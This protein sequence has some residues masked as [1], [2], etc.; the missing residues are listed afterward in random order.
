MGDDKPPGTKPGEVKPLK[1]DAARKDAIRDAAAKHQAGEGF[2]KMAKDTNSL[3]R[4]T[5]FEL[6]MKP[7]LKVAVPGTIAF[8]GC[9]AFMGWMKY[10]AD[11]AVREG[12]HYVQYDQE[13]KAYMGKTTK[14]SKWD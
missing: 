2:A 10:N 11:E 3:F 8:A 7:N 4:V 5:S 14:S 9:V 6:F 12:T 13:G 1:F